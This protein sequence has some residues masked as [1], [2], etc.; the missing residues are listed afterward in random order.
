MTTKTLSFKSLPS[1]AIAEGATTPNPGSP[2]V[3]A[4]SQ[5]LTKPV[6]WNGTSWTVGYDGLDSIFTWDF[7]VANWSIKPIVVGTVSSG[8]V[9][10]YT[11]DGVTRYRLV[12]SVYSA[13][14]D[15]FYSTYSGGT[16]SGLITNRG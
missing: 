14:Q 10:G 9:Y 12:P 3:L 5:T 13:A 6:F 4:W 8:T 1:L 2:G 15:A 11:L 16:L 7:L